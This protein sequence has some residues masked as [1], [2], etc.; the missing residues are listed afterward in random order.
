L[1]NKIQVIE[2]EF[3]PNK[4]LNPSP[5]QEMASLAQMS[6]GSDSEDDPDF[7][8]DA[9]ADSD[10]GL[11]RRIEAL[12]LS[13]HVAFSQFPQ[14]RAPRRRRRLLSGLNWRERISLQRRM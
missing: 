13:S 2:H 7:T 8:P 12:V 11:L 3:E 6:F 9:G 10:N 5:S 14:V 4:R 1:S